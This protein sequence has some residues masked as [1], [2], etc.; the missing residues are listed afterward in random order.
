MSINKNE[1]LFQIL[2]VGKRII[3]K[4]IQSNIRTTEVILL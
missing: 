2:K 4:Q 3:D 1:K